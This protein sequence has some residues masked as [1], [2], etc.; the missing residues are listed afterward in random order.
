ML[1]FCP[2][3]KWAKAQVGGGTKAAAVAAAALAIER[4]LP[5]STLSRW[6]R[7]LRAALARR[8]GVGAEAGDPRISRAGRCYS[9]YSG[10]IV[11]WDSDFVVPSHSSFRLESGTQ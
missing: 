4:L 11:F 1:G 5:S 7:W 8:G 3:V 9:T 6:W 2:C 10:D